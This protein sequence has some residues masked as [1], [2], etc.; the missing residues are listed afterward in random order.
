MWTYIFSAEKGGGIMR[1]IMHFVDECKYEVEAET[2]D[3]AL[4]KP[5][6]KRGHLVTL[7]ARPKM[8]I[9]YIK[10]DGARGVNPITHA[11]ESLGLREV[12]P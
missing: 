2:E 7:S 9:D 3:A 5:V 4:K 6:P 8:I 10:Q 12:T 11:R 1:Y